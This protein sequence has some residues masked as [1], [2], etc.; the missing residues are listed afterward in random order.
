MSG[1]RGEPRSKTRKLKEHTV[2]VDVGDNKRI[3]AADVIASI[4]KEVGE[5]MVEACV[6]KSGNFFEITLK[7]TDA[8]ELLVDTGFKVES[9]SF[10][11]KQIFSEQKVVSFFNVSHYVADSEITDKLVNLGLEV[12]SSMKR[13]VHPGTQVENGTRYV[14]VKFNNE[15]KS[16][17]YTMKLPTGVNSFEYIRV[18]H[19]NQRK[20]CT[21]CFETDHVFSKCPENR[22]FKCLRLGH[23]ARF[24]NTPPC[25]KC[26]LHVTRC[27][28]P[29]WPDDT[30]ESQNNDDNEEIDTDENVEKDEIG[31]DDEY[32]DIKD[33]DVDVANG[34]EK[35]D[36]PVTNEHDESINDN[37][38]DD[39]HKSGENGDD[40]GQSDEELNL[41]ASGGNQTEQLDNNSFVDLPV[42]KSNEKST[43]PP[44]STS[45]SPPH[46]T[47]SAPSGINSDTEMTDEELAVNMVKIRRKRLVNGPKFSKDELKKIRMDPRNKLTESNSSN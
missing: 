34:R 11:P 44:P 42:K 30:H 3:K 4:E 26:N 38:H 2:S 20:V 32:D 1:E 28:C 17:P 12:K 23:L 39:T 9:K 43:S 47:N 35:D 5:G 40:N 22:C 45:Q 36:D 18:T 13:N 37:N 29:S 24:C 15:I 7:Q 6:P 14:V 21:K 27:K 10:K 19:D 16:L 41:M 33:D 8:V 46:H 31:S 25:S